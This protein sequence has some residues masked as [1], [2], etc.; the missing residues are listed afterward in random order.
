VVET[1]F[2]KVLILLLLDDSGIAQGASPETAL[3]EEMVQLDQRGQ[4]S[5]RRANHH[6]GARGTIQH[7]R[8]QH[9]DHARCRH[10]VNNPAVGALLTVLASNTATIERMPAIMDFNFLPDMGRMNGR[11]LWGASR[12]CSAAWIAGA[13]VPRSCTA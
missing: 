3:D 9:D 2:G 10:D 1:N 11:W 6:V 4:L 8:R 7:P 13:S 5:A 12:G